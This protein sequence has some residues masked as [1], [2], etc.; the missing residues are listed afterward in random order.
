MHLQP[1]FAGAPYFEHAPG[2]DVA[3]RL[4]AA[5]LCLPS[6][7]NL[8]TEQQDRVIAHLRWVLEKDEVNRALV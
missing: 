8:S 5:G 1:L 4:F 7:S 6:G 3:A 2:D